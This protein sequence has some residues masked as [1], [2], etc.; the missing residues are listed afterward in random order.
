M[1]PVDGKNGSGPRAS[2]SGAE[3]SGI[4]EFRIG[5]VKASFVRAD[6]H[7][8][9]VNC[10]VPDPGLMDPSAEWKA[11]RTLAQQDL[12][13]R[14]GQNAVVLVKPDLLRRCS[15]RGSGTSQLTIGRGELVPSSYVTHVR[16]P[17]LWYSV[18]V[19]GAGPT[20]SP[21]DAE[22]DDVGLKSRLQ[23]SGTKLTNDRGF[24][25]SGSNPG[26]PAA[27]PASRRAS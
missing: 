15:V 1:I 7:R 25:Q 27:E 16:S 11:R 20:G 23:F 14:L 17:V 9:I 18:R 13:T 21:G 5:R 24:A 3:G 26:H 19:A 22:L 12:S 4:S 8:P 2:A 10:E 6:L